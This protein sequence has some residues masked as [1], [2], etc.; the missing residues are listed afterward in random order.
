MLGLGILMLALLPTTYKNLIVVYDAGMLSKIWYVPVVFLINI[1]TAGMAL[2]KFASMA[3]K[4]K[5]VTE[6]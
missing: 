2:Y 1:F 6:W 3:F 5:E 4:K